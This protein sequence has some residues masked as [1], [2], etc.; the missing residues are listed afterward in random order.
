MMVLV[1]TKRFFIFLAVFLVVSGLGFPRGK[2]WT[3]SLAACSTLTA[4]T[5]SGAEGG[6]FFTALIEVS[7]DR[8]N[9][10]AVRLDFSGDN[11]GTATKVLAA[12]TDANCTGGCDAQMFFDTSPSK[13]SA[14]GLGGTASVHIVTD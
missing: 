11:G 9:T 12:P 3:K 10:V 4:L 14:C 13:I 6:D 8:A 7:P 2:G 5:P 1:M